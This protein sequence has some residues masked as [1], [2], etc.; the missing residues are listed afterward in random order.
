M[1]FALW[2]SRTTNG[3]GF[4]VHFEQ[5][6]GAAVVELSSHFATYLNEWQKME[7][8]KMLRMTGC[9]SMLQSLRNR[10]VQQVGHHFVA[11][12][13]TATVSS[14]VSHIGKWPLPSN[15]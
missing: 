9:G 1:S 3:A 14:G 11:L 6:D 12:R 15:Q 10:F 2:A 4:T 13:M 8:T 7:G 5:A